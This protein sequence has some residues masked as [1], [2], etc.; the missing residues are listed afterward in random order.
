VEVVEL[1]QVGNFDFVFFHIKSVEDFLF[2]PTRKEFEKR[3]LVDSHG[4][5]LLYGEG[6][7]Y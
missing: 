2:Y 1:R 6:L 7:F 4:I 3:H 5:Y